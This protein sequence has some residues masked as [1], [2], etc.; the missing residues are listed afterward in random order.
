MLG[1]HFPRREVGSTR[2]LSASPAQ[3]CRPSLPI[4]NCPFRVC[5]FERSGG[6]F[7]AESPARA[8]VAESG[9]PGRLLASDVLD[10]S[11][12]MLPGVNGASRG[13]R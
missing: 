7:V 9:N 1:G 8:A 4:P 11:S 3:M 10:V 6:A 13:W 12:V 5:P 2:L